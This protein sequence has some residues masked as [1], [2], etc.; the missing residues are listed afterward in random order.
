MFDFVRI[1]C[2]V[3]KVAVANTEKNTQDII[4]KIKEAEAAKSNFIVFP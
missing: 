1:S 2:C 4:K 3:P